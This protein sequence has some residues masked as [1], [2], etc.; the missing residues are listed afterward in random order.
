MVSG[1]KRRELRSP[2]PPGYIQSTFERAHGGAAATA[3]AT[4]SSNV[5]QAGTRRAGMFASPLPQSSHPI[6][7]TLLFLF[8]IFSKPRSYI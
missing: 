8:V 4:Y 6:S 1:E 2:L 3:R 7:L 5:P